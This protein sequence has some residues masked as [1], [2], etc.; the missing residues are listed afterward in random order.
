VSKVRLGSESE[1]KEGT[2]IGCSGV[3]E[4]S[5]DKLSGRELLKLNRRN[6]R[7]L[8]TKGKYTIWCTIRKREVLSST[9]RQIR[10]KYNK[11]RE[12]KFKHSIR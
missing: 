7:P 4:N 5:R 12:Q 1:K 11:N 2:M 8:N 9:I 6:S 3:K 10:P